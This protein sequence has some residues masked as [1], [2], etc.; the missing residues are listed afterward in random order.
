MVLAIILSTVVAVM[1]TTGTALAL[2]VRRGQCFGGRGAR[3]PTST[4]MLWVCAPNLLAFA[5][6]AYYGQPREPAH[7][8]S[9]VLIILALLSATILT[10]LIHNGR[11]SQPQ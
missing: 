4:R 2:N 7:L 5:A 8:P 10:I 1:W 11:A 6:N 3:L 9:A